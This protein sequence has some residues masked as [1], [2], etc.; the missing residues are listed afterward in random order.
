MSSSVLTTI[1]AQLNLYQHPTFLIVGNIGN[2]FIVI[3]F[4]RQRQNACAIYLMSSAIVNNLFLT[5][6]IFTQMFPFYY[7]DETI[8]AFA[9]CKLRLYLLNIF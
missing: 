6:N 7:A 8:R 9:L 1:Q 3:L 2:V 5:F 4:S